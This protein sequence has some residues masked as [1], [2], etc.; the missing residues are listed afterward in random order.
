MTPPQL[1]E[2]EALEL[3]AQHYGLTGQLVTLPG[4][5]DRNFQLYLAG[6]AKKTFKVVNAA[7]HLQRLLVMLPRC[8]QVTLSTTEVT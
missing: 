1:T 7:V 8:T 3:L 4:E 5:R 2:V 6:G